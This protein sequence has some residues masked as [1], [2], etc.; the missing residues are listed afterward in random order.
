MKTNNVKLL[1]AGLLTGLL[2]SAQNVAAGGYWIEG[3]KVTQLN[4]GHFWFDPAGNGS[5]GDYNYGG[6]LVTL[7]KP[8]PS[9]VTLCGAIGRREFFMNYKFPV[10]QM[11]FTAVVAA[12]H[13]NTP[14][15]IFVTD[16]CGAFN[17]PMI[18]EIRA[19]KNP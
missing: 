9:N 8:L 1:C 4:T 19:M 15:A 7:D 13:A 3:A 2:F 12:L 6:V 14:V 11:W 5:R 10:E 16:E 17:F 18:G